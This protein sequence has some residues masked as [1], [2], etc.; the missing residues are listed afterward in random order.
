CSC[1]HREC[2]RRRERFLAECG[3]VV[4]PGLRLWLPAWPRA[5]VWLRLRRHLRLWVPEHDDD[6][7]ANDRGD[8][9]PATR[10]QPGSPARGR[11]LVG[12]L[13]RRH[14]LLPCRELL[15]LDGRQ[16]AQRTYHEDGRH[17]RRPALLVRGNRRR[18]LR[19]RECEVLRLH[20]RQ[21]AEQA[22]RLDEGDLD[23]SWL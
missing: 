10:G 7:G 21:A 5:H 8:V 12:G 2:G 19:L 4:H 23:G 11:L 20:G 14:L 13:R 22:G 1:S 18:H 15:R 3:Y 6:G 9:S 16:A 17:A